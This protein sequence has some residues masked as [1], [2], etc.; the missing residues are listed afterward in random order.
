MATSSVRLWKRK[1]EHMQ[2]LYL[3]RYKA[4]LQALEEVMD[5]VHLLVMTINAFLQVQRG[6]S[7]FSSLFE[8]YK[9]FAAFV[10]E[11]QNSNFWACYCVG[12]FVKTFVILSDVVHHAEQFRYG[13][14][15]AQLAPAHPLVCFPWEKAIT[16]GS[17]FSPWDLVEKEK[18]LLMST[19]PRFGRLNAQFL[20]LTVEEYGPRRFSIR[21]ID[22]TGRDFGALESARIPDT[23]LRL[24]MY[25]DLTYLISRGK[26]KLDSK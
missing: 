11:A 25:S 13:Y 3:E 18:V 5:N 16:A 23:E 4:Q 20:R 15:R 22:E 10:D 9:F 12:L 8:G 1:S 14:A 6:N 24:V 19:T 7:M 21:A 17:Y 2:R 26:R